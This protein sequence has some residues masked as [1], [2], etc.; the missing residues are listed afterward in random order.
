MRDCVWPSSNFFTNLI[1][2]GSFKAKNGMKYLS[3]G[4][5]ILDKW[6]SNFNKLKIM[7]LNRCRKKYSE[8]SEQNKLYENL[9][10]QE[11]QGKKP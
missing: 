11:S 1:F 5:Q 10:I 9:H 3:V 7:H 4:T 2:I 6:T 8:K